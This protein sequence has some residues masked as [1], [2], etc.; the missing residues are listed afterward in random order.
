[1]HEF[2]HPVESIRS[3]L[4]RRLE[5][6]CILLGVTGSTAAYKSVDTARWLIRRGARVVPVLTR[7]AARLVTPLLFEWATGERAFTEFAGEVGHIGVARTCDLVLVAPATLSTLAKIACGVTDNPVALAAVSALGAGVRV[8]VVPAMHE[9]MARTPQYERIVRELRDMG[10]FVLPPFT[11]EGVAK[12]PDPLLVARVA[13][14][15][16]DRGAD[17][18]GARILVT[19]GP[20]REWI[21]DVRFISNPSS[22]LM[23]VEV[24][25]EAYARGASVT[26]VHGP[27]AVEPPYFLERVRV[28]TTEEMA[29]AVAKATE[30]EEYDAVIAAAAPA[31]YRPSKRF[32]GKVR[33]GQRLDLTL[34]PTPKVL[35]ALR[36]R[37]RVLVAFAAEATGDVG[38]L[39][40]SAREKMARYGAALVVANPVGPGVGFAR[41]ESR[42]VLVWGEGYMDAGVLTKEEVARLVLDR[43]REALQRGGER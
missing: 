10:V 35:A 23:G 28:E 34:E 43:V 15:Y 37:P 30:A 16:A 6:R 5:G 18:R 38:A 29:E 40:E 41:R 39:V 13:A 19:A 20:T 9:N 26:L 17:L 36:R 2:W 33:S 7:E 8:M 3:T 27:L 32:T 31:D 4:S 11:A 22:G 25:V 42:A 1:M 21:D 24:A 12:Y 14:A